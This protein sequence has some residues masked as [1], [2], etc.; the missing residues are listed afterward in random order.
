MPMPM[1][2]P[3]SGP[4]A[5]AGLVPAPPTWSVLVTAVRRAGEYPARSEA[6]RVTRTVLSALA[7][8]LPPAAR[9]DLARALPP[10]AA[11]TMTRSARPAVPV[12]A[13]EFVDTVAARLPAATR[14]TARWDVGSVLGTLPDL[15]DGALVHRVLAELPPGYALLFGRGELRGVVGG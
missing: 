13:A 8:Q 9:A 3:A 6:V 4:V 2:T 1:P 12:P 15:L 14:A 5:E 10:T 7:A 11:R